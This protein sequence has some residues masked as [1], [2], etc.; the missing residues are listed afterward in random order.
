MLQDRLARALVNGGSSRS[1]SASRSHRISALPDDFGSIRSGFDAKVEELCGPQDDVGHKLERFGFDQA[2]SRPEKAGQE[3]CDR[4]PVPQ[5]STATFPSSVDAAG[6][7]TMP[8]RQQVHGIIPEE[9]IRNSSDTSSPVLHQCLERIDS[10]EA[11]L[12]FMTQEA[13]SLARK[14]ADEAEGG[15]MERK[16]AEK[17]EKI[18][19]LMAEGQ[20]LSQTEVRNLAT[21]RKLRLKS[22]E[23]DRRLVHS[24]YEI[25]ETSQTARDLRDRLSKAESLLADAGAITT[26]VREK[27]VQ[28]HGPD[29]DK[30]ISPTLSDGP[31]RQVDIPGRNGNPEDYDGLQHALRLERGRVQSLEASLSVLKASKDLCE[32]RSKQY[33]QDTQDNAERERE[34]FRLTELDL[35]REIQVGPLTLHVTQHPTN[36]I[37]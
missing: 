22:L 24:K 6:S 30:A 12:R 16:L 4:E 11:K 28:E 31:E 33:L 20:G 29:A 34:R 26:R 9:V 18:A 17:D 23:D 10:L 14:K 35:R 37:S 1:S 19:L 36:V 21:I 32:E 8:V 7:E 3:A 5:S 27:V 25:E 13:A 15:S 2:G